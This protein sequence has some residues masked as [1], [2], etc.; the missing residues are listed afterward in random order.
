MK[1]LL[2]ALIA[3]TVFSGPALA[4][5]D[6]DAKRKRIDKR[7]AAQKQAAADATLGDLVAVY[8]IKG[9]YVKAYCLLYAKL[10]KDPEDGQTRIR[11]ENLQRTVYKS[12][13]KI[14]DRW[15][16]KATLG[17]YHFTAG[18]RVN[19]RKNWN[20]ALKYKTKNPA[21]RERILQTLMIGTSKDAPIETLAAGPAGEK[22]SV[23]D[24]PANTPEPDEFK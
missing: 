22:P 15:T 4:A 1:K 8:T 23:L 5:K 11:L 10:D 14:K 12:T 18:D 19:A 13:R 20:D 7:T 6:G 24:A 21:V 9:D 2:F 16:L 3:L 17:F